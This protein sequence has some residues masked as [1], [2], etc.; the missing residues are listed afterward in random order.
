[1]LRIGAALLVAMLVPQELPTADA[2]K[3][4]AAST[5]DPVQVRLRATMTVRQPGRPEFTAELLIRRA[6][7]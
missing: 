7:R 2:L 4:S 1:M 3:E 6:G 5:W